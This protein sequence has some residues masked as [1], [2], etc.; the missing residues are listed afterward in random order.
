MGARGT[1]SRVGGGVG[2]D[3]LGLGFDE[4]INGELSSSMQSFNQQFMSTLNASITQIFG[5]RTERSK[6]FQEFAG[7]V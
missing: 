2:G 4:W 3:G 6:S 1:S 7:T 5:G